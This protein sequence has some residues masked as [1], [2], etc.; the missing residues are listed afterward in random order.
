LF[1]QVRP[2]EAAP[3]TDAEK[4]LAKAREWNRIR[5]DAL[6]GLSKS[7]DLRLLAYLGTA[8]LRTDGLPEF[9]RVLTTASQWLESYWPQVYP[10]L[11][12]YAIERRNALNCFA[13]RMAVVDRLWRLPLVSSRVHGRFSLR[14]IDI[15]RGLFPPGKNEAR[16][17]EAA[18]Q[19][20]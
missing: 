13:D 19:D 12:E 16:P 17:E 10:L 6:E 15:A 20:A 5:D 14:D 8:M 4:E 11:D 3:E 7:K 2:L 18:I 1:G 9:A